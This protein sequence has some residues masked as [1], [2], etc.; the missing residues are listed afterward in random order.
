MQDIK[1][2]CD[3]IRETS[4]AIH[5]YH[6]H[7]HVEKIYENALVNRLKKLGLDV[8]QQHS[9]PVFDEDGTLLG[10]L[11]AD[12]F[13]EN[14]LIVELKACKTLVDEHIAQL[15]GYLRASRKEHGLLINFGSPKIQIQKFILDVLP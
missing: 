9:L 10:D 5:K 13:V 1:K 4:F 8:K 15:L 6:R 14:E 2:L 3:V 7:G 11:H 12:L